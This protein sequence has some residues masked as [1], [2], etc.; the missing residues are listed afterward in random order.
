M[1]RFRIGR[2]ASTVNRTSPFYVNPDFTLFKD[3]GALGYTGPYGNKFKLQPNGVLGENILGELVSS[4]LTRYSL[5]ARGHYQLNDWANVFAQ[6]NFATTNVRS[7]AQAAA[8]TGGFCGEHPA[9]RGSP[10][11]GAARCPARLAR[12]EHVQHDRVRSRDR[13]ADHPH[14]RGC[15]LATEP[16]TRLPAAAPAAQSRVTSISS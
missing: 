14:R 4:P 9:R 10:D 2:P 7:F 16:H 6:A 13:P 15:G 3:R 11:P 5:I 1:P 8:A 12:S